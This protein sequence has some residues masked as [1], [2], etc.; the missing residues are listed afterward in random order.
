MSICI[1]SYDTTIE[2]EIPITLV[3]RIVAEFAPKRKTSLFENFALLG[4]KMKLNFKNNDSI[5]ISRGRQ[6]RF[7]NYRFTILYF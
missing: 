6:N 2:H 1:S 3:S 4:F 5:R 7:N